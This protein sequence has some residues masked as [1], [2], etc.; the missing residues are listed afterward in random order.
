MSSSLGI[1]DVEAALQHLEGATDGADVAP[2]IDGFHRYYGLAPF[3]LRAVRNRLQ[4]LPECADPDQQENISRATWALM[5]SHVLDHYAAACNNLLEWAEY[6]WDWEYI[7]EDAEEIRSHAERAEKAL[8]DLPEANCTDVFRR[9][10]WYTT[11]DAERHRQ[12][13]L[14]F[15][16]DRMGAK[17]WKARI[18]TIDKARDDPEEVEYRAARRI[19]R[20]AGWSGAREGGRAELEA[21]TDAI[22]WTRRE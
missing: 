21:L 10:M 4:T 9:A 16:R 17:D 14:K 1:E 7:L 12:A 5:A 20:D 19:Y 3:E 18:E 13:I 15:K 2:F 6:D 8:D 22:L 11:Y